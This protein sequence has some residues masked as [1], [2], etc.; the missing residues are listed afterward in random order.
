MGTGCKALLI[1]GAILVALLAIGIVLSFVYCEKIATTML[2]KSVDA[3]ELQVAKDLPEG[4]NLDDVK[5]AFKDFRD[6]LKSGNIKDKLKSADMQRF[7]Q[8][9]QDAFKD[10]KI[11][12]YELDKLLEVMKKITGK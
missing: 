3:V 7:S 12:K 5:A 8:T 9:I 2:E 11:D 6:Y 4:Y 1:V 10:K